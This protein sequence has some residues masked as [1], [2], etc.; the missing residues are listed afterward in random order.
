M[1]TFS[2]VSTEH[3]AF[4]WLRSEVGQLFMSRTERLPQTLFRYFEAEQLYLLQP[5]VEIVEA[6]RSWIADRPELAEMITIQPIGEVGRDFFARRFVPATLNFEVY[7]QQEL[8]GYLDEYIDPDP[9]L[10]EMRRRLE[11]AL[12][13][14]SSGREAITRSVLAASLLGPSPKT[15]DGDRNDSFLVI[16][17]TIS[18]DDL[19][20]WIEEGT[21]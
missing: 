2:E 3:D 21:S 17:P 8:P 12:I 5:F 11:S 6:A 7:H 15:T 16:E 20:R 14:P 19:E 18:K 4:E 1:R 10:P 9:E 13:G